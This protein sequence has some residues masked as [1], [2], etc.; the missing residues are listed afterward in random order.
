MS[1]A[2]YPGFDTMALHA[3]AAHDP[4]TGARVTAIDLT[5]AFALGDC[6]RA[7]A[8]FNRERSGHVDAEISNPTNAV[9]E[10]RI[11][12]LEG[13][14]AG[15]A[16]ATGQAALH[17][18][19]TTI[20]ACGAHIVASSALHVR[21]RQLLAHGLKR[22][23]IATTFV[24][25]RDIDG[26]RAAIRP[27]TRLLLAETLGGTG[28]HVLDIPTLAQLAHD[29]DVPLMVDA[30][31]TTPYLLRPFEH[32]ADLLFHSAS[33][34][35]CG[36]GSAA[37]G[38]LV[39]AGSFDWQRA[40]DNSGRYGDLCEPGESDSGA[41]DGIVFA[42]ESTVAAFALRARQVG[43]MDFGAAMSPHNAF[44]IL[45]GM[46][47]LGLRM[48]RHVANT[49]KVVEFLLTHPAVASVCYPEL[50][51][52][53]DHALARALLPKGCGGVFTFALKGER[54]GAWRFIDSLQL[55]SH[56]DHVGEARSLA[57]HPASTT[58]ARSRPE[59]LAA[60]GIAPGTVRLSVGLED[61]DDLIADL[62]RA[63]KLS[64]KGA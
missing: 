64:Q 48:E 9:L 22:C 32:G 36:H 61:P 62:A 49:R 56:A 19:L 59:Q 10:E 6:D 20:A 46:A 14:V 53:P 11:A 15:I 43:L 2:T 18:G 31:L 55:F 33:R 37:G 58:D 8:L 39:D 60:A 24:D 1:S 7:S 13:G 3:G 63:L 44:A 34:F 4:T 42:E 26:W 52:H 21:S 57:L 27:E 51:T 5:S 38:L 35:L 23:G 47:T 41:S 25:P 16:T 40:H 50:T 28:L 54:A 45:Q 17:L 30:S 12:A 29:H